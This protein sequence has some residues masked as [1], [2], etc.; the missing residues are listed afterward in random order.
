MIKCR[1]GR[2]PEHISDEPRE[3]IERRGTRV[4]RGWLRPRE[5]Q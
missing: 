5:E 2:L 3:W 1:Q 4:Q